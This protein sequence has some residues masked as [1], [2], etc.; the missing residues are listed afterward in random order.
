MKVQFLNVGQGDS[1][2]LEW[3]GP[4]GTSTGII[5]SC[6][7]QG[8]NRVLEYIEEN[9]VQ[10]VEFFL[11]SHPHFDHFSGAR[12]VLEHCESNGIIINHFLHTSQQ[13][14]EY[15]RSACISTMAKQELAR[16][17]KTILRLTTSARK[18]IKSQGHVNDYTRIFQL[19]SE[20]CLQVLAPSSVESNNYVAKTYSKGLDV[21]SHSS[22]H[23][24]WLST[25]I[26][27]QGPDKYALLTSDVESDVL[28]RLG[29]DYDQGRNSHWVW[30]SFFT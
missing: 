6:M 14:P 22:P 25:L 2:I 1:I 16:L 12:E 3:D 30:G 8:R 29:K 28:S 7:H 9:S 24:N 27:L 4:T 15:L 23:G 11:I 19:N 17:F 21:S 5:D 18:I 20:W 13:H 10:E 26:K